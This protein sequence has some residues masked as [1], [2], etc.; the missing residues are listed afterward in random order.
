MLRGNTG[1][2]CGGAG[3]PRDIAAARG[4]HR[5]RLDERRRG[6]RLCCARTGARP[7][8]TTGAFAA[9]ATAA[10]ATATATAAAFWIGELPAVEGRT[11]G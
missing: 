2:R 7:T 10:A 5:P 11:D 9:D 4:H 1:R 6:C 8:T 3:G